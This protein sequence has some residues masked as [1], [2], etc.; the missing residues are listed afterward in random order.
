MT[1]YLNIKLIEG[2]K[3]AYFSF[4]AV[5][6]LNTLSQEML[7]K[8]IRPAIKSKGNFIIKKD[9]LKETIK[10]K[11]TDYLSGIDRYPFLNQIDAAVTYLTEI[12]QENG[13]YFTDISGE[14]VCFAKDSASMKD[15]LQTTFT[16]Y[17]EEYPLGE[18]DYSVGRMPVVL[19]FEGCRSGSG[20]SI[21]YTLIIK[22]FIDY[23]KKSTLRYSVDLLS[24]S[25]N[26]SGVYLQQTLLPVSHSNSVCPVG[27]VGFSGGNTMKTALNFFERASDFYA[28]T[29][30]VARQPIFFYISRGSRLDLSSFS[31][32]AEMLANAAGKRGG[33]FSA[34][35]TE[36]TEYHG[37]LSSY[38]MNVGYTGDEREAAFAMISTICISYGLKLPDIGI[39]PPSDKL[40]D[41]V[42]ETPAV[43]PDTQPVQ[44]HPVN[45]SK[46]VADP[47]PSADSQQ[48]RKEIDPSSGFREITLKRRRRNS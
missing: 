13:G 14:Y 31:A 12:I 8:T 34:I 17:S 20:D 1:F 22:L 28:K 21:D 16:D 6:L 33:L 37:R 3:M 38:V 39:V 5:N 7:E 32:S 45:D 36:K 27:N 11:A 25:C 48:P 2:A 15:A 44:Q 42:S 35:N 30:L 19:V 47:Q 9:D 10:Q 18:I 23:L 43:K 4:N 40:K 29:G 24:V 41:A 26:Q 46:P